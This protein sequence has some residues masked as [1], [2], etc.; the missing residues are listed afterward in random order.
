MGNR[1]TEGEQAEPKSYG[2]I[3]DELFPHYLVMGMSPEEYWDG[4]SSLK[5]AYRIAYKLRI[6][7]E[8]QTADRNMWMMGLYI[9]EALQSV[10]IL[11]NGFVPK[12]STAA[13]YPEKP[14]LDQAREREAEEVRKK[15]EENQMMTAIA[16][17]QA[18]FLNF[19]KRFEKKGEPVVTG[20]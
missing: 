18:R 4:E 17:M 14:H 13:D 6:E 20:E 8:Q 1:L 3:F 10:Y 5:K 9:R 12:G 7:N 11:V 16:M 2:D 19:N 15:Q